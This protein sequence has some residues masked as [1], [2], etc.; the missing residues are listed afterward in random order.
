[1]NASDIGGDETLAQQLHVMTAIVLAGDLV[2]WDG[3][4]GDVSDVTRASM[5]D[6]GREIGAP[7]ESFDTSLQKRP[8]WFGFPR[9]LGQVGSFL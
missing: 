6:F 5:R 9:T 8:N 3:T 2:G 1:M 4:H 7:K